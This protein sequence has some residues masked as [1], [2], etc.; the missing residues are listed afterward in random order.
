[1]NRDWMGLEI[2]TRCVYVDS[3]EHMQPCPKNIQV[4]RQPSIDSGIVDYEDFAIPDMDP[5]EFSDKE[6]FQDP[7]EILDK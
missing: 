5:Q 1:M 7:V 2:F 6:D 4:L 3:G